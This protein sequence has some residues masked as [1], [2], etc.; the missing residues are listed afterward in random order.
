MSEEAS[1]EILEELKVIKKWVLIQGLES[2]ERVL[3][4]FSDR[5]LVMYEAADGESTTTEIGDKAG[6]DRTTVSS[7][8]F[9]WE[10]LGI[11]E[12]DGRQWKHVA[13]LSAMGMEEPDY[14]P[15]DGE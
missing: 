8:M 13:P 10:E 5:D 2:L 6:V 3:S 4:N 7:Y 11:V 14:D 15:N 12:K 1:D 9:D